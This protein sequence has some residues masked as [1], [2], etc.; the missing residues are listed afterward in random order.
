MALKSHTNRQNLSIWVKTCFSYA[1]MIFMPRPRAFSTVCCLLLYAL[2]SLHSFDASVLFLQLALLILGFCFLDFLAHHQH[3]FCDF[4]RLNAT[5][6]N[7]SLDLFPR[8]FKYLPPSFSNYNWRCHW[9]NKSLTQK[10][11][12]S[13]YGS[14]MQNKYLFK[15]C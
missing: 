6:N 7:T 14:I 1:L 9:E 2:I 11:S 15:Q 13:F 12:A 10:V 3:D 4:L 8:S 5:F